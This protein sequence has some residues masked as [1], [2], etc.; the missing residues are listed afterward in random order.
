MK[1]FNYIIL[2]IQ[3]INALNCIYGIGRIAPA[4]HIGGNFEITDKRYVF[5]HPTD[6]RN[7]PSYS[8]NDI[9][10][11]WG[12]PSNTGTHNSCQYIT[13]RDGFTWNIIGVIIFI[14]PIPILIFPTGFDEKRIYFFDDKSIA[15][16]KN[17]HRDSHFFGYF[18]G[19]RPCQFK[20]GKSNYSVSNETELVRCGN[21]KNI[22]NL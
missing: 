22:N 16:S 3:L 20:F 2:L 14:I 17:L 15:Y 19:D 12:E 7:P 1:R 13:Y 11:K 21:P 8:K 5:E 4:K 6:F 18:C 9:I 10:K